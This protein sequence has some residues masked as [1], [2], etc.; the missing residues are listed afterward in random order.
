[1]YPFSSL[2]HKY[3]DL[4]RNNAELV[5]ASEWGLSNLT[6]LLPDRF[7]NSELTIEVLHACASTGF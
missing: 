1:M 6:W 5:S 3:K 7:N 4:V 2:L